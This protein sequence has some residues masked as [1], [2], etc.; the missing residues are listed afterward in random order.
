MNEAVE[1]TGT[2]CQYC[3]Q[4]QKDAKEASP[5][6]IP[7]VISALD[8]AVD[9]TVSTPSMKDVFVMGGVLTNPPPTM[10]VEWDAVP[11]PAQNT[12]ES[13]VAR[14]LKLADD[15]G[16]MGMSVFAAR[17]LA[18]ELM[19][20]PKPLPLA[21]SLTVTFP[22]KAPGSATEL[23]HTLYESSDDEFE[24]SQGYLKGKIW[25]VTEKIKILKPLSTGPLAYYK[26][27]KDAMSKRMESV[28]LMMITKPHLVAYSKN[29]KGEASITVI[30]WAMIPVTHVGL[31]GLDEQAVKFGDGKN[32]SS[33]LTTVN[34]EEDDA[35]QGEPNYGTW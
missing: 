18:K 34:E 5:F 31:I 35:E 23:F 9:W 21:D 25:R 22:P 29:S 8:S 1:C 19:E 30:A 4:A 13:L 10:T 2:D 26:Q 6:L 11:L 20:T 16:V 24:S 27:A 15:F 14:I 17:M 3:V 12:E 7:G 28:G 32:W 33:I